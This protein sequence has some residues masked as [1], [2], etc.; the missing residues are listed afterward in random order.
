MRV[1]AG[2]SLCIVDAGKGYGWE[3]GGWGM[4][5]GWG[6]GGG[7]MM[8]VAGYCVDGSLWGGE[9]IGDGRWG[10]CIDGRLGGD[11]GSV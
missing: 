8:V 6:G 1:T 4:G 9:V 5:E 10:Y 3:M 2:D 11:G 7:G